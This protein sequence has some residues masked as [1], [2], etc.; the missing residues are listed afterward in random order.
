MPDNRRLSWGDMDLRA[1]EDPDQVPKEFNLAAALL[2]RH[3]VEGRGSH[4]ALLGPCG[5][6]SYEQLYRLT[7]QVGNAMSALGVQEEER[8]LLLRDSPEFVAGFLAAMKIGAVAVGLNTFTH[9]SDYDFYLRH[10][11]ARLL[12]AD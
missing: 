4:R 5:E 11:R 6:Y 3:V 12:V 9:P 7:N 10:S 8:V 1:I 2:D